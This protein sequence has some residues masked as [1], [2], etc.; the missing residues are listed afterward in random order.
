MGRRGWLSLEDSVFDFPFFYRLRETLG[1]GGSL[2]RP[3]NL[4]GHD[5]LY[6]IRI[7]WLRSSGFM[8]CSASCRTLRLIFKLAFTYLLT[9]RDIPIIYYDGT[10]KR[11]FN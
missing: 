4:L 11:R 7:G 3:P 6:R 2:S 9:T 5:Y 1:R 8:M 10:D